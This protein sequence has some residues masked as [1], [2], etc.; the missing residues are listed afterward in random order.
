MPRF[1]GRRGPRLKGVRAVG[2]DASRWHRPAPP[3]SRGQTDPVAAVELWTLGLPL[4]RYAALQAERAEAGGWDGILFP[5][6][7]NLA[8]DVYVALALAA[9]ATGRL[10]RRNGVANPY[11]PHPARPAAP[12]AR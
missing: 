12:P 9:T 6:S 8:G 11:T 5:D 4:P 10:G 2:S 1:I 7:Q 3:P